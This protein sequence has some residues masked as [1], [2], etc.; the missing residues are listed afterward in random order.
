MDLGLANTKSQLIA[1]LIVLTPI[2]S[3]SVI[4][5]LHDESTDAQDDIY[6]V[7]NQFSVYPQLFAVP[8]QKG[9]VE[10]LF[11]ECIKSLKGKRTVRIMTIDEYKT[12][13]SNTITEVEFEDDEDIGFMAWDFFDNLGPYRDDTILVYS[14][15]LDSTQTFLNEHCV[16]YQNIVCSTDIQTAGKGLCISI[17]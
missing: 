11:K 15:T 16:G 13:V 9:I 14:H 12:L 5:P 1:Y 3:Q 17:Q 7:I 2:C 8:D 6:I 4:Q 10:Y